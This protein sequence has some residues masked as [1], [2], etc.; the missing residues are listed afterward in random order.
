MRSVKTPV[1]DLSDPDAAAFCPSCGAGYTSQVQDCSDC[2]VALVPKSQI[3]EPQGHPVQETP[4][5]GRDPDAP[6]L[7]PACGTAYTSASL[8]CSHCK[9]ALVPQAP[10]DESSVAS[11]GGPEKAGDWIPGRP[12]LP[13]PVDSHPDDAES[14][15]DGQEEPRTSVFHE[16]RERARSGWVRD[17]FSGPAS[18]WRVFSYGM[19]SA[20]ATAYSAAA[21]LRGDVPMEIAGIAVLFGLFAVDNWRKLNDGDLLPRRFRCPDCDASIQLSP[22]ERTLKTFSCKACGEDFEVEA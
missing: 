1:F 13:D 12:R 5:H 6:A 15:A 21:A 2:G 4:F 18:I 17:H 7:C 14:S 10:I 9:V 20:L 8:V 22:P 11:Q 3:N 19:V 16:L